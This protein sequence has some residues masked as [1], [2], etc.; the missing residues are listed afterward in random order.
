MRLTC[1]GVAIYI[2]ILFSF[3]HKPNVGPC[4]TDSDGIPVCDLKTSYQ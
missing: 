1:I 3:T 4:S 2:V